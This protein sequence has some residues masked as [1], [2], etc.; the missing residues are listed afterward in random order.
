[1]IEYLP[2]ALSGL[3][4]VLSIFKTV[5]DVLKQ[6]GNTANTQESI[7]EATNALLDIKTKIISAYETYSSLSSEKDKLKKEI[8]RLKDWQIER[9]CYMRKQIAPGVFAYIE[10]DFVGHFQE[11][12]KYCCNCFDKTIKSTLQQGIRKIPNVMRVSTLVCPN[13]CPELQFSSYINI[14]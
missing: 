5:S 8:M 4:S 10:N 7:I 3:N 13:G 2:Q 1:M 6:T 11:A 14:T 12:H 9:E